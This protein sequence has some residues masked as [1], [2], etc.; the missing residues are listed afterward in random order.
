MFQKLKLKAKD[1]IF[2]LQTY[3]YTYKK[4]FMLTLASTQT[5]LPPYTFIH[6]IIPLGG[7]KI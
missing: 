1:L 5:P 4:I 7:R 2:K 6:S 3:K